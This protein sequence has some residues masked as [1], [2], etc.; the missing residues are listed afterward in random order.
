MP[1]LG[2]A[3]K[4]HQSE[5]AVPR[6]AAAAGRVSGPESAEFACLPMALNTQ[7]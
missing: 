7:C 5:P 1:E 6:W 4:G 2:T 3:S